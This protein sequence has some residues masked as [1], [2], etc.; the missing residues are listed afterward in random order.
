MVTKLKIEDGFVNQKQEP[1]FRVGYENKIK[2]LEKRI[3][4]IES[5][6][7]KNNWSQ[8]NLIIIKKLILPN[9]PTSS[10]GLSKG[11]LWN[12]SGTIKIV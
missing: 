10:T 3:V 7:G 9:L 8:G 4:D 11:S 12:N 2:D 1:D 5:I 6:F